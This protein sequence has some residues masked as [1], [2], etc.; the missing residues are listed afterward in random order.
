MTANGSVKSARRALQILEF[1]AQSGPSVSVADIQRAIAAPKSS[2][3]A[4][5]NTLT[6]ENWLEYDDEQ[7]L[8]RLGVKA[9]SVGASFLNGSV[10]LSHAN[11]V[12]DTLSAATGETTHLGKI[13]GTDVVYLAKRE[14]AHPLRL[15]SA[16]GRRLPAHATA[17][18]KAILSNRTNAQL[19]LLL[20]STLAA[21]TD[22]T[23]TDRQTLF[24]ELDAVRESGYAIDRQENELGV[25]CLAVTFR[26][27]ALRDFAL[28]CSMPSVRFD[29]AKQQSVLEN[30]FI[31]RDSLERSL[32]L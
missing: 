27:A 26:R 17:L 16:V 12:L 7:R 30:L 3:Y 22:Y 13:E 5:L 6:G 18:G 2:L 11:P 8:Y 31:A 23:I 21:L 28:S 29:A 4:L 14:S 9:L 32:P 15:F 10:E 24:E 20:P 1:V 19:S 25:C